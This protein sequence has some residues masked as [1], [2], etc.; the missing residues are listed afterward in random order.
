MRLRPT[1]ENS[2]FLET[3]FGVRRINPL[4]GEL[5]VAHHPVTRASYVE[6]KSLRRATAGIVYFGVL[7]L[8][9]TLKKTG[10]DC[11]AE[12]YR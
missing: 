9:W 11:I 1:F 7:V 3:V 5:A 2:R 8:R 10:R 4:H 6:S 12:W